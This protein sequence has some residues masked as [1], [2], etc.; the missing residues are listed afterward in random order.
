MTYFPVLNPYNIFTDTDGLPLENGYIYIGE[1]NLNPVTNP[2]TVYWD[3]AGLYPAAQPIRTING[4]PSRAGSAAKIYTNAGAYEDYSLLIKDRHLRTVHYVRSTL[5]AASIQGATVDL[6]ADLRDING[7]GQPIYVRGHTTIGDGGGGKFE[8]LDG[9]APGT[10]VDDNGNTIVPAGGDGSGAWI[11]QYNGYIIPE[12]YGA[13]GDGITDDTAAIQA[14]LDNNQTILLLEKTYAVTTISLDTEQ[15]I[16]GTNR[17]TSEI[18]G[19]GSGY[20]I[21]FGDGVDSAKRRNKIEKIKV[22]NDGNGC[23]DITFS[24]NWQ[25]LNCDIRATTV[26]TTPTIRIYN[27]SFRGALELSEVRSGGGA[28]AVDCLDNINGLTIR[29]NIITGG[30]AGGALRVGQSQ[31]VSINNNLIETSDLGIYVAA[32]TTTGDGNCNGIQVDNNYIEAVNNPINLAE[33]F[34]IYGAS[35]RNNYIN[36]NA[37][38]SSDANIVF[39][40]IQGVNIQNNSIYVNASG[41]DYPFR[42]HVKQATGDILGNTIINNQIFGT[43]AASYTTSG[44]YGSNASVRRTIGWQND[45]Q[46]LS[47][48]ATDIKEYR[49][50]LITENVGKTNCQWATVPASFGGKII[51]VKIIEISGTLTNAVLNIGRVANITD[52]LSYTILSSEKIT[53]SDVIDVLNSGTVT[54]NSTSATVRPDSARDDLF[55]VVA[56]TGT[57]TFRLYIRYKVS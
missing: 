12:F 6:I 19:D 43:P 30:S 45:F 5:T 35:C 38:A 44:T 20:C 57:G 48:L 27:G 39:G 46:F 41:L 28:W 9:A 32:T 34:S 16:I 53:N 47:S 51:D 26:T 37:S 55:R 8:W 3:E 7:Y 56:G 2:I 17:D 11:R 18:L 1:A 10:Y 25:I 29:K 24:P 13:V 42:M 33:E 21:V 40:R 15:T 4:Y 52:L 14:A 31:D 23:V 49:S 22:T 36:S 54:I 50:P